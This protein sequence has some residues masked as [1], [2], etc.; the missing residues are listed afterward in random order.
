VRWGD[1]VPFIVIAAVGVPVVL[2]LCELMFRFLDGPFP[3]LP[4]G[5]QAGNAYRLPIY[6]WMR[7]AALVLFMTGTAVPISPAAWRENMFIVTWA[8]AMVACMVLWFL[9]YIARRYDYGRAA[10]ES[11]PWFHWRY[12]PD[13]M[14]TW[15]AGP[16]AETWIG[17]DG[18]L[19]AD[20]YA[21]WALSTYELVKAKADSDRPRLHFTF[22]KTSFGDATSMEVMHV[23]I[24]EG[25]ATDLEVI[26]RN[27][28]ALCPNAEIHIL[29]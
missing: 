19:F 27:L 9:H 8:T 17:A 24:P 14:K 11:N 5:V 15:V 7:I 10:L 26:D 3:K 12:T 13:E 20:E 21:P 1:A 29:S 4:P 2:G 6:R 23:P 18:L 25:H 28:R 22:K 16:G